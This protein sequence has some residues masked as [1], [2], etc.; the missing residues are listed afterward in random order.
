MRATA[1][2]KRQ[3]LFVLLVSLGPDILA[4]M[5]VIGVLLVSLCS[6]ASTSFASGIVRSGNWGGLDI[7]MH[8]RVNTTFVEFD[9]AHGRIDGPILVDRQGHFTVSGTYVQDGPGPIRQGEDPRIQPAAYVGNV[10]GKNMNVT[11]VL[12][13]TGEQIGTFTLTRG[14]PASIF[15]CL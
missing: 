4:R 6:L 8:V 9:C 12:V 7:A 5:R 14:V 2:P 15:K 13:E 11:V 10:S 1:E 3:T